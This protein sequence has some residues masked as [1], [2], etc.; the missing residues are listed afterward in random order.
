MAAMICGFTGYCGA[1]VTAEE[2]GDRVVF[3][4]PHG[5]GVDTPMDDMQGIEAALCGDCPKRNK[6][7]E[8]I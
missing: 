5:I 3:Q 4:C 8:E 7:S 1:D 2:H 6:E